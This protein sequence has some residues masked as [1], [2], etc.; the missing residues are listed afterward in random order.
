[1]ESTIRQI[2]RSAYPVIGPEGAHDY[3]EDFYGNLQ[4]VQS[5]RKNPDEVAKHMM[6]GSYAALGKTRMVER[7]INQFLTGRRY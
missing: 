5:G 3:L 2:S 1:M 6:S 7:N 4:E